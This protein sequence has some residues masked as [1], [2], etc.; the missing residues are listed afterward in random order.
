[1]AAGQMML[2]WG[3]AE[4]LA[5]ATLLDQGYE[6]RLTGQDSG[7]G[8]F[9][10]RHAVGHDQGTGAS[11][12]PLRNLKPG[13][14]RFRVTDSLLSEEAVLGFEYGYS[15]A[16]PNCLVIWEGQFGDFANGAQVIIDQFIGS[17]EAKWGRYCSLTLFLPHGYEGQGPEHSSARL[18]RFLQL[19]AENNM[20]V[21]VPSTPA[22]MFH[23]LRR[24]MLRDFRKPLIV[25]TPK[26]LLRHKLSV[27]ALEDLSHGF[28][29][30]VIG[31]IDDLPVAAINRVVFCSGKVYFDLLEARRADEVRDVAIIRLE[32]LYPFPAEDYAAAIRRYPNAREVV[33]CQEEPQNQGAWYQI[34]H[35]LQ[36]PL[37]PKQELLYSGRAP[38][39]AP[40]TGIAQ[41]HTIQQN[42]LVAAA[43]RA[44]V[45]EE[46]ARSTSRLRGAASR[47][48]S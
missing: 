6:V 5:Y 44:T 22:Q 39:A 18:E 14:P 15:T 43:I 31:E 23:M 16:D 45:K 30:E 26:S 3:F 27:S 9:F 24:Q 28:F 4:T 37:G 25:M 7:R 32:Q 46:S 13:Q 36:E 12:I 2:D 35:R 47:K 42:G 10:H 1:M 20:S 40:A 17:G 29:N 41:L 33:W 21:C 11:Y 34:R 8:T 38:A 48:N 19:C